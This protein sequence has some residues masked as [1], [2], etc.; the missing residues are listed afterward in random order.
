MILIRKGND[1]NTKINDA[2]LKLLEARYPKHKGGFYVKD[3]TIFEG[4]D[5]WERIEFYF[6]KEVQDENKSNT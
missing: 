4:S 3:L 6:K 2:I 5:G 1:W